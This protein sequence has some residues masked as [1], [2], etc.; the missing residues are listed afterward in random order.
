VLLE[1]RVSHSI[2][3][4]T[5]VI[6]ALGVIALLLLGT[7]TRKARING[8]LVPQQGMARIFAPQPGVVTR[9]NVQEGTIVTKGTPLLTLSA[10]V[11]SEIGASKE[12]IVRQLTTRRDSMA[13]AKGVQ[14]QLFAQQAADLRLRLETVDAEQKHLAT[15]I[16]IQRSRLN[17]SQQT[18]TRERAMRAR[19][20]IALPRL[21]RTEQDQLD[22]AAR[23]QTLE[24]S[25]AALQ[26][27]KVQ[28]RGTLQEIPYRL[29][30]QISE[31]ERNVAALEQD[32]AEAEARRQMV[33]TAPEE[34]VVTAIQ[35]EPGS[36]AQSNVPLMSIVPNGSLLQ[37]QLFAPSRAIGFIRPGQRVLLRYHPYPYQKFGSYEGTVSSVSRTA[38][39][40]SELT[41]QL[42]GLTVLYGA[43]EPVYRITV[44]LSRQTTRA[45]GEP[46][47]LQPGMQL[48]ADVMIET[49]RLIEWVFDPLFTLTGKWHT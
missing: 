32:L 26:R 40:P 25:Q 1:P 4:S 28:V 2:F 48:E 20:L 18:L 30:T 15:E 33:V 42:A 21:Q 22:N 36:N 24:R 39:S 14:Q 16:D 35:A 10:E 43:N 34:G 12:E 47:P 44:D 23:L 29:Q 49:R 3:A 46:A 19:D 6:A 13:S 27:E 17:L 8:W 37:A 7:Y 41:Q 9:I 45:Y 5:A 11:R 31:L 38:V